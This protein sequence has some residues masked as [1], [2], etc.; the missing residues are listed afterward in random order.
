MIRNQFKLY[1]MF[2]LLMFQ[3]DITLDITLLTI[4]AVNDSNIIKMRE[5]IKK[6]YFLVLWKYVATHTFEKSLSIED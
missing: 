4:S 6:I 1:D 2:M 3:H 5:E